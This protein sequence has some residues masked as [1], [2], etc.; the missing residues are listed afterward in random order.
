[1][2]M[3]H[4]EVRLFHACRLPNPNVEQE[5]T[6]RT[7]IHSCLLILLTITCFIPLRASYSSP[8]STFPHRHESKT[9]PDKLH[10]HTL[11]RDIV[12]TILLGYLI[13]YRE[14]S[15]TMASLLSSPLL[16]P[17]ASSV[18]HFPLQKRSSSISP[19]L[20]TTDPIWATNAPMDFFSESQI[21]CDTA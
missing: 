16:P 11:L 10:S 17:K 13:R 3:I 2:P 20:M 8:I 1:M 12:D 9:Q 6:S 19:D 18:R 21:E 7:F 5:P 14:Q 4:V 15:T